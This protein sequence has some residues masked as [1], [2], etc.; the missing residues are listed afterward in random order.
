MSR[1]LSLPPCL[2]FVAVAI[3]LLPAG[4]GL[5]TSHPSNAVDVYVAP[6]GSD[7]AG[8]G[9]TDSPCQ[10]IQGALKFNDAVAISI[11][12]AAGA[13]AP[14]PAGVDLS[15][16]DVSVVCAQAAVKSQ[17]QCAVDCGGRGPFVAASQQSIIFLSLLSISNCVASLASPSQPSR[18]G[19]A[20]NAGMVHLAARLLHQPARV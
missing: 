15:H 12:L 6:T 4:A 16:R 5:S 18:G 20:I 11:S 9:E 14:P 8:C 17:M 7:A 3:F 13:Y 10:T 1:Q 19:G 2:I